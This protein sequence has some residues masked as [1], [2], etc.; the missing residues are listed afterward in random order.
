MKETQ[1]PTQKGNTIVMEK[2]CYSEAIVFLLGK[3]I[4]GKTQANL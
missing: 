1:F 3:V 2:W 4:D